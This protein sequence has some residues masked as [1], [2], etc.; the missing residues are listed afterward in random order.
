MHHHLDIDSAP[1]GTIGWSWENG[2]RV[3]WMF[4]P[5]GELMD[6]LAGVETKFLIAALDA[7]HIESWAVWTL[8]DPLDEFWLKMRW[9]MIEGSIPYTYWEW[10]EE[11]WE[12]HGDDEDPEDNLNLSRIGQYRFKKNSVSPM[13]CGPKKTKRVR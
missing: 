11:W 9:P 1:Q 5:P 3:Y 7:Q 6:W 4:K 2:E 13:W 10:W 12:D 8:R